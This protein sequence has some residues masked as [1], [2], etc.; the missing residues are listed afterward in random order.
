MPR[1]RHTMITNRVEAMVGRAVIVC[2]GA[3]RV[4]GTVSSLVGWYVC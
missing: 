3:C 1:H 4:V 2:S